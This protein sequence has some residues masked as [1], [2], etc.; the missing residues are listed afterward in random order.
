MSRSKILEGCSVMPR[1]VAMIKNNAVIWQVDRCYSGF[2]RNIVAVAI[3]TLSNSTGTKLTTI[4]E[5]LVLFT[6]HFNN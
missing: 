3:R 2:G 4:L 5:Q 1:E 6:S